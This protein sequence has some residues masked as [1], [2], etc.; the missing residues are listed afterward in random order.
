M[1]RARRFH[2]ASLEAAA[3]GAEIPLPEDER[4]HARVLRLK[5]GADLHV[6]DAHGRSWRAELTD[7]G[8]SARLVENLAHE[9]AETPRSRVV[10]A[11]AWPKG[12][13]AAVLVEKCAELGVREIVPLRCARS[14]VIKDGESEGVER[15][16]RIAAE[17]AKQSGRTDVP[18][19]GGERSLPAL[20]SDR[21]ASDLVVLLDPRAREG[22]AQWLAREA[23]DGSDGAPPRDVILLIGPEGGFS[24][25]ELALAD[26]AGV[27]RVRLGAHILRVETACIAACAVCAAVLG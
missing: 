4:K 21:A 16:R 2:V 8:A 10:L 17:A 11:T 27:A 15:L 19:I 24:D 12:K 22:L 25:E 9:A 20:V 23:D 1:A 6:F 3:P 5:P 14:V 18:A 26:Q 7:D 13:R